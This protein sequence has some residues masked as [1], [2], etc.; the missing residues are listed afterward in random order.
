MSVD[1]Q[2][3]VRDEISFKKGEKN[4]TLLKTSFSLLENFHYQTPL[5]IRWVLFPF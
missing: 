5:S 2:Q 4:Q 3:R 1:P